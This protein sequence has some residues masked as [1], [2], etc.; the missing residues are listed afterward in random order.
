MQMMWKFI[1]RAI[2]KS[3]GLGA[4]LCL[5]A[6]LVALG[7]SL[8]GTASAQTSATVSFS[9]DN[10]ANTGE[11]IVNWD[12]VSGAQGYRVGW[13]H[14]PSVQQ[15]TAAGIPWTERFAYT[16]VRSSVASHAVPNLI[17]GEQYAFIIGVKHSATAYSWSEWRF[18][19]IPMV[20]VCPAGNSGHP[21]APPGSAT[22]GAGTT[23][24]TI[25]FGDLNWSSALLQN[26]IAQYLVEMG[27]GY[28]TDVR[29]GATLPLFQGLG[30]GDIDVLMEIWLPNQDEAWDAARADGS[31]ISL[32]TSLGHHWQSAFVIPKYLQD[33]YPLLD[34]VEDLKNPQYKRLFATSETGGKAR[35]VSCI[36]G[37]SCEE[38]N[39]AQVE[40]YGLSDHVLIVNPGDG[41][42]LNADLYG[43][44]QRREPWLGYQ[45]G[46]NDPALKLDLVRLE[47][48]AYSDACWL[49]TKACA[50]EDA[51]V[52]IA[53][54][55]DLPSQAPDVAA[56]L[57]S[58]D[59]NI[60]RYKT[61]VR[62]QDTNLDADLADTAIWWLNTHSSVW[63]SWVTSE[64]ETA[65]RSALRAG[66]TPNGWP[67]E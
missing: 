29:F 52:L 30:Y 61:V 17:G 3:I 47:E 65:I 60:E 37:W 11:V 12:S 2:T 43:A 1:P 42:A 18:H 39:A 46:T 36:I 50:Y 66:H 27:Y 67:Q 19:T 4:V 55:P 6:T 14:Y 64:A 41:A 25:T 10:S 33:Q 9:L 31:V 63:R 58:W 16:D 5:L 45:W 21:P 51:T 53:A 20:E 49:T 23:K 34:S 22:P 48:P 59:F 62:W 54:N 26:R 7:L 24:P 15:A 32:G 8:A 35:L 57:R 40:A 44:Y 38:V 28:P 56:M 13:A